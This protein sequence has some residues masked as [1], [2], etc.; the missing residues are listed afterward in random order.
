MAEA[1]CERKDGH[2]K[3]GRFQRAWEEHLRHQADAAKQRTKLLESYKEDA[4][5]TVLDRLEEE[6]R[7][8]NVN[9]RWEYSD[10]QVR[11]SL[12]P[13]IVDK[14]FAVNRVLPLVKEKEPDVTIECDDTGFT[15]K[16]DIAKLDV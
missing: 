13:T 2:V 7:R 14:E 6:V 15:V 1:Q 5:T 9:D 11:T 16:V 8:G 12:G 4:A 3:S 10:F